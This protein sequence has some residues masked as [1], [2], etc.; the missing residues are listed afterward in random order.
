MEG[1]SGDVVTTYPAPSKKTKNIDV[2]A[3]WP[4][5]CLGSVII[6]RK[7]EMDFSLCHAGSQTMLRVRPTDWR[8]RHVLHKLPCLLSPLFCTSTSSL[9]PSA[10]EIASARNPATVALR[11]T[12]ILLTFHRSRCAFNGAVAYKNNTDTPD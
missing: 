1:Q 9:T 4:R 12:E 3:Q 7:E 8:D 5:S 2:L 10:R 11:A 6:P